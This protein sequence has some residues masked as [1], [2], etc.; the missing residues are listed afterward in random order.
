MIQHEGRTWQDDMDHVYVSCDPIT[1]RYGKKWKC[2]NLICSMDGRMSGLVMWRNKKNIY[3]IRSKQ[4]RGNLMW[5][6]SKFSKFHLRY[7]YIWCADSWQNI[8]DGS[9][10]PLLRRSQ[11]NWGPLIRSQS[12]TELPRCGTLTS[13]PL[14]PG[15]PH[16]HDD[17][18]E[19]LFYQHE[20][21]QW[22]LLLVLSWRSAPPLS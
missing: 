2:L 19:I 8:R 22:W 18:V 6:P 10:F 13:S 4:M 5:R 9:H 17:E 20:Q 12:S 11:K 3:S 21:V 14:L 15:V 16:L 7:N 1:W